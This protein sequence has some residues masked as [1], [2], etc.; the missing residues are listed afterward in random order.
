MSYN[1]TQF[2]HLL[3]GDNVRFYR[4]RV[5]CY[6][7]A[8]TPLQTPVTSPGCYQCFWPTSY[9][10]EVPTTPAPGLQLPAASPGCYL[11]FCMTG[12]KSDVPMVPSLGLINSLERL[13]AFRKLMYSLDY[14]FTIKGYNSRTARQKRCI[15]Q[16]MGKGH[17]AFMPS[18][19]SP[20]SQHFHVFTSLEAL[21]TLSVGFLWRLHYIGTID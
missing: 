15:R 4:L 18:P 11:Y 13:T 7:T 16:G 17:G 1:I 10:L 21:W 9:R 14:Q 2:W 12:Y 19:G 3:P 20:L 5:Q 6:K 8:P